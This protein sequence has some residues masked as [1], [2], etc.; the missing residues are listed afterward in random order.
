MN[1]IYVNIYIDKIKF[2]IVYY[3]K[4]KK[5]VIKDDEIILPVSFS[6]G[7]KLYYIKKLISTI[8]DQ[9]NIETY[10][11]EIDNDVGV[12]IIDSVKIEG[13]LEELFSSKGVM[14]WK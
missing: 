14:L 1:H 5:K 6:M 10:N 7:D 11:L 9:Y 4:N 13:V 3:D 12:E 8:I 2:Y